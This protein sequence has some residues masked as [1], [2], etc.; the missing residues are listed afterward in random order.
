VLADATDDEG[1]SNADDCDGAA[2]AEEFRGLDLAVPWCEE[3]GI[4]AALERMGGGRIEVLV[5]PTDDTETDR[6]TDAAA[7]VPDTPRIEGDLLLSWS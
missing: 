5:S 6:A 4:G 1:P 3:A 2:A 7:A